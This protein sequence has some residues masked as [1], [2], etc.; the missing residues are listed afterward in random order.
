MKVLLIDTAI[1]G[2]HIPYLNALT[3][4][5]ENCV[6]VLP[7]QT[8]LIECMQYTIDCNFAKTK[9]FFGYLKWIKE[10]KN[11]TKKERPDIVHF[12]YGDSIFRFFGIGLGAIHRHAKVLVIFH[13]IRR[14][15]LKDISNRCIAKK[16]DK[17][18]VH[19]DSLMN[20]LKEIGINNGI[21]IEY[22]CFNH[23][24]EIDQTFAQSK[25]GMRKP[26]GKVLLALGGTRYDKGLNIL[27]EALKK[28]SQP[29][30]LVIA[31][32]EQTF[33]REYIENEIIT[34]KEKV[35][36]ILKYLS[37]EEIELCLN[38]ADIIILPYRKVFDGASGPLGEGVALGKMIVGPEHGSIGDLIQK[39]KLGMTFIS[40]DVEN[41]AMIIN[42][43]L[44]EEFWLTD[45]Y[46]EYQKALDRKT[47]VLL[48]NAL[49]YDIVKT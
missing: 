47:F 29:F 17:V 28:V 38:S 36:L 35:T 19:T 32:K 41:L 13:H 21:H 49:Y 37:E 16:A 11:I 6:A 22:P 42:K 33:T 20:T 10:I 25:I 34:Y 43:A 8:D 5:T 40:E 45:A 1:D 48:Y 14:S 24:K 31:G 27:L 44:N 9:K 30:H 39:H 18:I 12:L 46:K 3:Q 15:K 7:E 26:E 4:S 23:V 2:H